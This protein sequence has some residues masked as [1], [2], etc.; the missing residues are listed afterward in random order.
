M[1]QAFIETLFDLAKKDKNIFLLN[2]DLGF[3]VLENFIKAYPDR[4]YN[5]GVAEANMVGAASGLAMGGKTVFVYSII[6]FITF[7]V[8]EQVRNDIALQNVN[9]KIVG[10]GSGMTYA[11]LGPTHHALEDIAVMRALPNMKVICP[12]DPWETR[13]AVRAIAVAKGPYYLRHFE[14]GRAITIAQGNDLTII[15]TGNMLPTGKVVHGLLGKK[16]IAARLISMHTI[17]PLDTA[18]IKKAAKETRAIFTLEE[19]NIMGGLGSAVAETFAEAGFG[20]V[21]QRFGVPDV[22]TGVAGSN[23]FLR[24]LHGLSPEDI[25]RKIVRIYHERKN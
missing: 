3:S 10:V 15:A 19:H 21:F 1:R 23:D 25:S 17:K 4:S 12:G 9:V 2:G 14:I 8:F 6:P 20:G 18:A 22:F 7:R 13:E 5:M 24:K 11:S 16:G